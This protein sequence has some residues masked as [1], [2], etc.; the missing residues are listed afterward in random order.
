MRILRHTAR[1]PPSYIHT[2]MNEPYRTG[3]ENK[4]I[5]PHPSPPSP[6]YYS[7]TSRIRFK[8]PTAGPTVLYPH[9]TT[10]HPQLSYI[11]FSRNSDHIPE[12][13]PQPSPA[14]S[15]PAQPSQSP[16]RLEQNKSSCNTRRKKKH[17]RSVGWA[18]LDSR[19][20]RD[21]QT[22]GTAGNRLPF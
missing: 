8:I 16:L 3:T 15:S 20:R 22:L 6:Q 17:G 14:Q 7:S 5:Y 11:H 1:S 10:P 9:L 13:P 21:R 2:H 12:S 18:P 4:F 19:D